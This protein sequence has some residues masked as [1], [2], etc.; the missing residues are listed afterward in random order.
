MNPNSSFNEIEATIRS[1][2]TILVASH[3]RP[4][5]DALGCTIAMTLFIRSL[6]LD[7]EVIAWNEDGCPQKFHY[8]PEHHLISKPADSPARGRNFDLLLALDTS[9]K[10]RL[11]RVLD[12]AGH[13]AESINIDH[14]ISNERYGA[15]NYIDGAAP[16]TGQ[17]LFDF[18]RSSH[19][20]ISPEIATNLYA[21]IS[22]DTGS[23]QYRGTSAHTLEVA[24][25]LIR[26]GVDVAG[27]SRAMYDSQPRRC[28]DLLRHALN[29]AVFS[30]NDRA[31]S[32][33]LTLAEQAAMG[34]TPDDNEGLIN[35]LRAV[36]S[37]VCAVFFEELP[38]GKVRVSARSKDPRVDVCHICQ[39]FG[40]GGHSLAAGA[41]V[42]GTLAE[43]RRKFMEMVDDEVSKLS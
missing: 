30:A 5:A 33:S 15:M 3:H 13:I 32:T 1:A 24:A 40:G 4:D 2:K 12:E 10:N 28:L 27:I 16:A 11:G 20:S 39:A 8:L 22:T 14:H 42:K 41:R 31:V 25:D 17:I 43:V 36:D 26:C 38:E 23:F 9:V 34:L 37:V 35:H 7:Q 19:A 29:D 18:F 21:A 6:G